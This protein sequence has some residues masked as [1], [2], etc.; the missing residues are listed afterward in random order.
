MSVVTGLACE[1]NV[2][3]LLQCLLLINIMS[4][5]ITPTMVSPFLGNSYSINFIYI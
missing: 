3:N 1:L 5:Q 4:L 2:A